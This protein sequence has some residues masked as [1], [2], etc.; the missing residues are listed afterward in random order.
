MAKW[1]YRKR[2]AIR[3]KIAS[4]RDTRALRSKEDETRDLLYVKK[5]IAAYTKI[6]REGFDM[7][8]LPLRV[9]KSHVSSVVFSFLTTH[10]GTTRVAVELVT[11]AVASITYD[12]FFAQVLQ[13]LTGH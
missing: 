7:S 13:R 11:A 8:I 5:S 2:E 4:F 1:G 12:A 6:G 10:N 9:R 3:E